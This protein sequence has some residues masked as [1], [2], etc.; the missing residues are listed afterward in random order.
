[1]KM[2]SIIIS[3]LACY[4]ILGHANSCETCQQQEIVA[5]QFSSQNDHNM[6][7]VLEISTSVKLFPMTSSQKIKAIIKLQ[8][9]EIRN[10]HNNSGHVID[11]VEIPL[12][13][14]FPAHSCCAATEKLTGIYASFYN[15]DNDALIGAIISNPDWEKLRKSCKNTKDYTL[16]LNYSINNEQQM[17]TCEPTIKP[18]ER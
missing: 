10:F 9:V 13:P 8:D 7:K 12:P 18:L 14:N 2:R 5:S 6:P 3:V 1:M 15:S 4:G 16:E 11:Y 17:I